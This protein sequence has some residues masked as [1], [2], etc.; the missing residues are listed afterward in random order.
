[1]RMVRLDT[2]WQPPEQGDTALNISLTQALCN[3]SVGCSLC[4][5][6]IL[7]GELFWR[8][9]SATGEDCLWLCTNHIPLNMK[10]MISEKSDDCSAINYLYADATDVRGRIIPELRRDPDAIYRLSPDD[11]EELVFDRLLAI[12]LQA[13]RIGTANEKD[14][15]IDAVFWASGH[16]PTLGAVQI[17]HHRSP[18]KKVGPSAVRDLVGAMASDPFGLGL[19]VTNTSFSSDARRYTQTAS[20]PI[21][22]RDGSALERWINDDFSVEGLDFTAQAARFCSERA[23]R[24]PRFN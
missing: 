6:A 15:G 21:H 17:K 10:R 12:G 11:F 9:C 24:L 2:F 5:H 19:V 16:F 20:V 22:L 23:T 1:M 18:A 3:R 4:Q 8:G 13:I 14:G 7:P